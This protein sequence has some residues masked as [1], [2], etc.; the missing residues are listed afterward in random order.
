MPG[1]SELPQHLGDQSECG[2]LGSLSHTGV[3]KEGKG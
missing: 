2:V 1:T 3:N